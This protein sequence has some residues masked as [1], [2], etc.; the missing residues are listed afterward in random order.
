MLEIRPV[1]VQELLPGDIVENGPMKATFIFRHGQ[2]PRYPNTA[3]NL[4]V[5]VLE[6]GSFSFDALLGMQEVGH[7]HIMEPIDRLRNLEEELKRPHGAN[8]H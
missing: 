3:L 8:D 5:W 6:D 7:R 4:V 2:H 1:R